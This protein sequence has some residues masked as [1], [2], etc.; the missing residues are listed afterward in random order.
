MLEASHINSARHYDAV[1]QAWGFLLGSSLHYGYFESGGESLE[2]ATGALTARM[3]KRLHG[4]GP[5]KRVLDAGCGTGMPA[6]AIARRFGC[7]VIGISPSSACI[8]LA[9]GAVPGDLA[10]LLNFQLGDAQAMAFADQ[11]FEAA[12]V[13]ESSHLMLDKR[14]LF[15][16]LRRVLKRGGHVVLCDIVQKRELALPE[17]IARRDDFLLLARVFGRALMRT[18]AFYANEARNAG[19]DQI[20]MLDLTAVTAPTFMQWRANAAAHRDAVVQLIG[21]SAWDDFVAASHIL[22][23]LWSEQV[24]GYFMLDASGAA[25]RLGAACPARAET[26]AGTFVTEPIVI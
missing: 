26:A 12:W 22:E 10:G 11:S 15:S 23:R 5:G 19:F 8:E 20:E 6:Q 16:E 2:Q 9:R 3:L 7:A 17:V 24:L 13:L 4:I 25:A 14:K 21:E 18:P 1:A